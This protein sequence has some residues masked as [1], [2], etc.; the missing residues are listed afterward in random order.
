MGVS[1]PHAVVGE[2]VHIRGLHACGPV[3]RKI[4]VTDIVGVNE[5]NIGFLLSI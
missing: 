5:D 1:E 4:A 3:A 2:R